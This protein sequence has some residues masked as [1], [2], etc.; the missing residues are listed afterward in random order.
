MAKAKDIRA[1]VIDDSSAVCKIFNMYLSRVGVPVVRMAGNGVEGLA[2]LKEDPSLNFAMVDW[3]MPVMNGMQFVHELKRENLYPELYILM[4]TAHSSEKHVLEAYEAGVDDYLM[5]PFREEDFIRKF[6][7][8]L[9]CKSKLETL[10]FGAYL[11]LHGHI[12]QDQLDIALECQQQL[13]PARQPMGSLALLLGLAEPNAILER[14]QEKLR[15]EG[16]SP[17]GVRGLLR[18]RDYWTDSLS[19][20]RWR[21][22]QEAIK[23]TALPLGDLLVRLGFLNREQLDPLLA[24]FHATTRPRGTEEPAPVT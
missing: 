7:R 21:E 11:V 17:K 8:M 6:E 3:V 15:E 16:L 24:R 23:R 22:L 14:V 4:L 13:D 5:K 2:R 1:L 19:P 10:R 9:E 20:E 18:T 12:G